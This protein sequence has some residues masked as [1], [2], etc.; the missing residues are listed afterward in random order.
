MAAPPPTLNTRRGFAA[1]AR[2]GH[3][4]TEGEVE[5]NKQKPNRHKIITAIQYFAGCAV[6]MVFGGSRAATD[7]NLHKRFDQAMKK[8]ESK[9]EEAVVKLSIQS[10]DG[11][12]KVRELVVQ[13][14]GFGKEQRM[15]ARIQAPTDLK[16][17]GLLSI[18]DKS[19]ENQWIYL[20]STKQTRKVV[21]AEQNDAGGVLGSELR[22]EDFN[23]SVIRRSEITLMKTETRQGV[24]YDVFE[25]KIPPGVSPYEKA[26]VWI[27]THREVPVQIDYF[28]K[29]AKVKTIF[30]QDYKSIGAVLRPHKMVIKNLK[31]Q[32]GTEIEVNSYKINKGLTLH[33]LSVDSLGRTW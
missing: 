7:P 12:A 5:K 21:M 24:G 3:L 9:D 14:A 11:S 6:F 26:Q 17:T 19:S 8:F 18:V 23:P 33:Q 32:R 25:T 2:R 13:R 28:S 27:D 1:D 10:P 20:P 22:Y 30:F 31:N 15:L 16:G 29:N 4:R